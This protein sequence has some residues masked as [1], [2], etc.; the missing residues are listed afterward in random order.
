MTSLRGAPA[1]EGAACGAARA[2]VAP[3]RTLVDRQHPL[4]SVA[5]AFNAVMLQGD[6]IREITLEGPGA[7]GMETASAVVAD[8]VSIVGTAGTG[9]LLNSAIF[10]RD[11]PKKPVDLVAQFQFWNLPAPG[12]GP[13]GQKALAEVRRRVAACRPARSRTDGAEGASVAIG[14]RISFSP[15]Q[16]EVASGKVW[17]TNQIFA[18]CRM[19]RHMDSGPWQRCN[20]LHPG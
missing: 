14:A 20:D 13:K 16:T 17:S 5:G 15:S 19:P 1:G 12:K 2:R 7:G 11:L 8:L 6:A 9:F 3:G 10:Q 18:P 4:A